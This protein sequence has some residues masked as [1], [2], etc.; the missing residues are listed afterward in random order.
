MRAWRLE[1][2]ARS[3]Y[4]LSKRSKLW[5]GGDHNGKGREYIGAP[6][7]EPFPSIYDGRRHMERHSL[8]IS[9]LIEVPFDPECPPM[10]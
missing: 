3:A 9:C 5:G 8:V 2:E 7:L 4:H 1:V 10:P 6:D